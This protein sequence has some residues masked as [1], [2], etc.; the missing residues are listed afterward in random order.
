MVLLLFFFFV[1]FHFISSA[2]FVVQT[3][4]KTTWALFQHQ[5][6]QRFFR[7]ALH[8]VRLR[9]LMT[10]VNVLNSNQDLRDTLFSMFFFF[11][12]SLSVGANAKIYVFCKLFGFLNSFFFYF[13]YT[14]N[15]W[16]KFDELVRWNWLKLRS[17]ELCL[18]SFIK[19]F[20][21]M[22]YFYFFIWIL[23]FSAA[24]AV[25]PKISSQQKWKS[26]RR[27][28]VGNH[29]NKKLITTNTF[30]AIRS[31]SIYFMTSS[32]LSKIFWLV[33]RLFGRWR[34]HRSQLV[35]FGLWLRMPLGF[36]PFL[37]L[38][39]LISMVIYP[40]NVNSCYFKLCFLSLSIYYKLAHEINA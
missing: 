34:I 8:S 22:M 9:I 38:N 5:F 4:H 3:V 17:H 13:S 29:K 21:F 10:P 12:L 23:L 37:G 11:Y 32:F 15:M 19:S 30:P 26:S 1:A 6:H 14:E 2:G 33:G 36:N 27:R 35:V 7:V 16:K 39:G 24:I 31:N 20:L 40:W 18:E 28:L 25:D